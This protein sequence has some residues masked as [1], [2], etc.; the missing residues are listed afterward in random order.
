MIIGNLMIISVFL[1]FILRLLHRYAVR[2]AK[3]LVDME[4]GSLY[5]NMAEDK[6]MIEAMPIHQPAAPIR[7][8]TSLAC[9]S[10][11]LPTKN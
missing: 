2:R 5:E 10:I 8:T 11:N 9:Y 3:Y 6:K 4:S 1:V 7:V